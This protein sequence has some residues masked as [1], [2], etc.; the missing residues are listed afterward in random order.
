ML[1]KYLTVSGP[2]A[3]LLNNSNTN[4]MLDFPVPRRTSTS[5]SKSSQAANHSK[6]AVSN[7]PRSQTQSGGNTAPSQNGQ[8]HT[9]KVKKG[10]KRKPVIL[11]DGD[12]YEFGLFDK[13]SDKKKCVSQPGSQDLC[14]VIDDSE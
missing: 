3:E 13:P 9:H 1:T 7:V 2:R 11:D 4:V 6:P 10:L 14:V 8:S 5:V 12:D